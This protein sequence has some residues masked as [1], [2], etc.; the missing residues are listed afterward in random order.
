MAQQSEQDEIRWGTGQMCGESE[1]LKSILNEV[2]Q[3]Q[4]T[5]STSVMI[6]GENG[7]GKELVAR[8]IHFGGTRAKGP[9]VPVNCTAIP[10]ELVEATFFGHVRGA[11]TGAERDRKG[12]FELADG[13]TLFLDEV[14]DMPLELQAKLLRVLEDRMVQPVGGAQTKHVDVRVLAATNT[15]LQ[16]KIIE[17]VFRQDFYYRLATVTVQVPPLRERKDDLPLLAHHFLTLFAGEMGLP[18]P[19]LSPEAHQMLQT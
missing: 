16:T 13:G 3:L 19:V 17:G 11:F 8:A 9:F 7:T 10:A 2:A 12:V 4:T 15:D 18:T 14:G 5:H 6:V 1:T